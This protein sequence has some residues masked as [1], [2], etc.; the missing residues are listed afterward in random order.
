MTTIPD[1][2]DRR[3]ATSGPNSTEDSG[4]GAS[5]AR[6]PT[7]RYPTKFGVAYIAALLAYNIYAWTASSGFWQGWAA[8]FTIVWAGLLVVEIALIQDRRKS[9]EDARD[10]WDVILY[11]EKHSKETGIPWTPEDVDAEIARL[12]P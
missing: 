10:F 7:S 3:T 8:A 9:H 12:K 6:R 2:Q 4:E 11:L 5:E 1:P